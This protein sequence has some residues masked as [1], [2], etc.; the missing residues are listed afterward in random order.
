[1]LLSPT[2]P[3]PAFPIGSNTDD[4]IKMYLE[5]IFT[6]HANL[7]GAPAISLPVSNHPESDLPIGIQFMAKRFDE[8]KLLNFSHN[9]MQS[10]ALKK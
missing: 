8:K 1:M 3:A 6:V 10:E 2:S 9:L 4:P 7:V 5:D